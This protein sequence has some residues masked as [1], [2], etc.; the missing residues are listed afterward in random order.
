MN[1]PSVTRTNHILPFAELSPAQFERLCLWLVEH[2]GFHDAEHLGE[3]GSEQGRDVVAYCD[4]PAG[5]Q[6]WY[7]QCK[8]CQRIS[9]ATLT[10]EVEKYND[11]AAAEPEATPFGIVFVTNAVVSAAARNQAKEFCTQHGY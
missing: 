5:R 2:E 11:L 1:K 8:R 3:A 10:R 7:F 4:T 9:A 6:M